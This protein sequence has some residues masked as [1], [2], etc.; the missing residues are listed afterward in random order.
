MNLS[1]LRVGAY[2]AKLATL[3]GT[4]SLL[5][6]AGAVASDAQE[7]KIAAAPTAENE[8]VPE[9]ILITGSLIRGTAPVGAPV[10]QFMP[11][12][13]V[14]TGA[15]TVAELFRTFPGANVNPIAVATNSGGNIERGA[16]V[17]I[18]GLDSGDAT[19]SLLMIDGIRFPAQGNG[20]D[21]I[22]PSV[23]PALALDHIDILAD[24]ASATYGS[25]AISGVIN[26]ILKRNMDGAITQLR[27][28]TAQGGKN[29]YLAS[30]IWGRTWDGGQVTLSYEWY[31]DSPTMGNAHSNLT[32]DFS[33]WGLDDRRPIGSSIPATLSTGAPAQPGGGK[34][35]TSALLGHGC[36]NCY[37]V[38]LG[39]G[40]NFD[41]GVGGLGPTAPFSASTLN[42][43]SFNTSGN[44]GSNGV[45]NQF[46]PYEISWYDAAQQ[47]NAAVITIDQRLTSN[48]SFYGSGFYSNRRSTFYNAS[49]V[50]TEARNNTLQGV[51]VPTF[52]PY[53]PTGGAPSNLRVSYNITRE[54][55]GVT[56][57]YE[58]AGRYQ[59][60]LNIA[61]PAGWGGQ[62]WFAETYDAHHNHTTSAV[63][64]NAVSAALGWTI[65]ATAAV[66]NAT[67]PGIATWTRPANVP[68]LN[69]FCDATSFKCNSDATLAYVSA[70]RRFDEKFKINEKG[71]KAD[72]PLFDLPGGAVKAAIGATFTSFNVSYTNTTNVDAPSLIVPY[73]TDS[74]AHQVWAVFT[75]V[76]IPVFSETNGIPFFRRLELEASWRH[77]QYSNVKGTSN[78]K[79]AF[80]WAP[81]D[82][83][84]V[85]G[86]WGTS[87]RAPTIA[88]LSAARA[89]IAGYNLGALAATTDD[90]STGCTVGADLPPAGS[91]AWKVQSSAGNGMPGSA[92][93][94]VAS[95]TLPPG[96]SMSGGSTGSDPIRAGGFNGWTGLKPELAT[97][98]GI[99]FDYTPSGNFLRGLN[100]RA[101]YYIIKITNRV[102]GFGNPN[103]N[104]FNNPQV[105]SFAF[106]V[107]TDWLGSGLPGAAGCT[108]NLLPTTC[109]PFQEAVTGLI[110]HPNAT[111][112]P[113]A[114]TLIMWI[115]DGGT[116]NKGWQKLDGVDWSASYDWD[117]GG[118]GA[119]SVGWV[120]TYY[121]H[122]KTENIPGAPGSVVE[123]SF[124]TTFNLG[125]VNQS[126]G[127]ES[128]PRLRYRARLGWS[129]GPW[130]IT[131]FM[132]YV[133]HFFHAQNPPPN[134]NGNFCATNGGLDANGGG[135]T[136]PCAISNYTN[137]QPSFYTFDVSLGYNT[138]DEPAN[139]YLRNIGIQLVIQN[140]MDR[141]SPFE[142]R[143]STGAGNP[144]AMDILKSNIGRTIS[145]IVTKEW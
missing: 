108:S 87:F 145:L 71:V 32:I 139:E 143:I 80:N 138:L 132:D 28:T 128:L 17:N 92:T 4:A 29:V 60:G 57:A 16:K 63:N 70:I 39:T 123:D 79:L 36:T 134:V 76:N 46:N 7:Q 100:I 54:I 103:S 90:I 50:G 75:Q 35:G 69:L 24:G 51:A 22:D 140:I 74:E 118:L 53:Y 19:R 93:A 41:P 137:L 102:R 94:C 5:T 84:I 67:T 66:V 47:R 113:Q 6:L 26:L 141:R 31:G 115:N 49:N 33:P 78:P 91:G 133:S 86:A 95:L 142:Y 101:T 34:I 89:F 38:P 18:R 120:G 131:G 121:L 110:T 124:H 111:V 106:L 116:F 83:L 85:R 130:S 122:N 125:E 15:L 112:S 65:G 127:V 126:N 55:P 61:L 135:G 44:A 3:L 77:D 119:F 99:G 12:D 30:A 129:N 59:L 136:F 9:T 64:K 104:F 97:N 62:V 25:D 20:L 58:L 43:S 21:S 52:N 82:D 27:W 8:A 144:A 96:I 48:I 45:R 105:G 37:A 88:E 72:G 1:A 10:T 117:W 14:R 2:G 42:W 114:Q 98:W 13:F 11:Q 68:Y 40:S 81:I 107:P 56:S 23:I 73:R 109:A